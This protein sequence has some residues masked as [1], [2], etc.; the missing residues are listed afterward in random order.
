M[1][2]DDDSL[3]TA[4]GG[5]GDSP[6]DGAATVWRSDGFTGGLRIQPNPPEIAPKSDGAN[7]DEP[8]ATSDMPAL[9]DELVE[10]IILRIPPDEPAHLVRAALVCK[11][12][13][14]IVSDRGFLRRYRE[15]HR[16][17]RLLGYIQ[18][19]FSGKVQIPRF[20]PTCA[21][22]S[23]SLSAQPDREWWALDCRHGRVLIEICYVPT[24]LMVWD[25]ITGDQHH[26][27]TRADPCFSFAAAVLCAT[28]SCDHIDCHGDP[29]RVVFVGTNIVGHEY[30]TWASI[31]SL[32]TGAWS[33]STSIVT[34]Y[35][36]KDKPSLLIGN[37]LYFTLAHDVSILKYDLD[38]HGLCE[39]AAPGVFGAIVVNT[40]NSGLG[41]VC[42]QD[43]II[44]LL[45]QQASANGI[46]GPGWAEL[47][48][49]KLE[50]LLPKN[51]PFLRNVVGF[52]EGTDIVF[53]ST[54]VG[55]FTL[56]LK[57][58]KVRK[59]GEKGGH[60]AILPYM[61]IYTP[62]L[63]KDRLSPP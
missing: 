37:A 59:V 2:V 15:L 54:D 24:G 34:Q 63:A 43:N 7:P 30:V 21:V 40:E 25:P 45:S 56:E 17:P 57:S 33:A 20:A 23:F 58:G 6:K 49:I 10:E 61:S 19:L 47:T 31:Y 62:N 13:H 11:P 5:G 32:E 14:R 44:Y 52:A 4:M 28:D 16:T 35:Y 60:Y 26:L 12:W 50:T 42:V 29:F 46:A 18:N 39:I 48:V 55:V 27:S 22:P 3:G 41:F 9:M 8:K 51:N 38:R 53:I 1:A 36:V